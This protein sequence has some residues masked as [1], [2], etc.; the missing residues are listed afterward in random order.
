M[1]NLELFLP[2]TARIL[3]AV[4]PWS[5]PKGCS[6][7]SCGGTAF[8]PLGITV[9]LTNIS[10]RQLSA[11]ST[12]ARASVQSHTLIKHNLAERVKARTNQALLCS[13]AGLSW[14]EFPQKE[15]HAFHRSLPV[16]APSESS[17]ACNSVLPTKPEVLKDKEVS[18]RQKKLI[19][20]PRGKK[21]LQILETWE[22][23]SDLESG[24]VEIWCIEVGPKARK[25]PAWEQIYT[26]Y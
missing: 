17:F 20:F 18:D 16:S 5:Q 10:L 23:M 8:I 2:L 6:I 19:Y 3:W 14:R 22:N 26:S 7:T 11:I 4:P 21:N 9:F 12:V 1:G 24:E 15:S 25:D 13:A